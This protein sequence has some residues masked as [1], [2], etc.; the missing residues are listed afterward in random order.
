MWWSHA[1]VATYRQWLTQ[2][3][4]VMLREEFVPEGDGGHIL[5]WARRWVRSPA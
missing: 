2:V 5:F 1:D 4:F 3:G